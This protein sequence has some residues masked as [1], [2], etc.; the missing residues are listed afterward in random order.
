MNYACNIR[1]SEQSTKK[2]NYKEMLDLGANGRFF[3]F[4]IPENPAKIP[5]VQWRSRKYNGD[6]RST[7]EIPEIQWKS[8]KYNGN[9]ESTMEI[10]QVR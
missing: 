9:P 6:P 3:G 8:Q 7:M 10:P 1:K 4:R 2:K 5:E